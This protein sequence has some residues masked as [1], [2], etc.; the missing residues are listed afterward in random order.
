MRKL[1]A[2]LFLVVSASVHAAPLRVIEGKVPE[3]LNTFTNYATNGGAEKAKQGWTASGT[4]AAQTDLAVVSTAAN[5]YEGN[6]A[7]TWTPANA[8][9][10]LTN[11]SV[12]ITSTGGLSNRDCAAIVWTKTTATTHV[13]EAYDGS[14]IIDSVTLAAST[15]FIPQTMNF[16]CPAS[17]TVAIRFNAGSTT[18]ITFDALKWGDAR[19]INLSEVSQ[20]TFIGSAHIP[21]TADCTPSLSSTTLTAFGTDAQCPGPTVEFNP[22]PGVIQ[23]TDTDLPQFTV[24]NLPPGIYLVEMSF[25]LGH[26]GTSTTSLAAAVNDGTTTSGRAACQSP[27]DDGNTECHMSI[28]AQF[29]YTTSGNRTFSAYGSNAANTAVMRLNTDNS[30]LEFRIV[31]FPTTSEQAFR[32]DQLA[33]NWSGYHASDC[34]AWTRTNTAYGTLGTDASCTFTERTNTNFGTVTSEAGSAPGF[35][36]TPVKVGDYFICAN[37]AAA[38]SAGGDAAIALYLNGTTQL[39]ETG[40]RQTAA[41]EG[42]QLCGVAKLT[43]VAST[44]ISVYGKAASGAITIGPGTEARAIDWTVF[45]LNHQKSMPVFTPVAAQALYR[46]SGSSANLSFADGA[47]EIADF[48]TLVKDTRSLVTTGAAWKFT[49]DRAMTVNVLGSMAWTSQTLL[50][51]TSFYIYVNGSLYARMSRVLTGQAYMNFA[52]SAFLN[53]GDYIDVRV[54]PDTS[55]ASARVP[56]TGD[57]FYNWVSITEVK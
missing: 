10:Y 13:L 21:T 55:D 9:N 54:E 31:R 35:V 12:T 26:S 14:S 5:I 32:A 57:N 17:G 44:T 34:G 56:E 6:A 51:S 36:F 39:A 16:P 46:M 18:A 29:S 52:G 48:D 27:A 43:S 11:A 23:T 4:S 28:S 3:G 47:V 45:Q 42:T 8:D 33:S 15:G 22:G 7:F 49:A 30:R 37:V 50:T 41:G 40:V 19:G 20:A 53:S 2:V 1:L 24:N 38:T 25:N